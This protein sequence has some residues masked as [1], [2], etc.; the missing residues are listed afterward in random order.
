MVCEFCGGKTVNKKVRK[1][2]WFRRELYIVDNVEA[3]VCKECGER[4]YHA[5]TLDAIERLLESDQINVK[6]KI[7]VQVI[8][9][10]A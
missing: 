5:T 6:E 10:P 1:M 7:Q 2:H 4:Y 8:G 3:K 9:M